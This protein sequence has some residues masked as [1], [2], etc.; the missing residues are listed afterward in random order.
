MVGAL[1]EVEAYLREANGV[2]VGKGRRVIRFSHRAGSTVSTPWCI[3]IAFAFAFVRVRAVWT[4]GR[5]GFGLALIGIWSWVSVFWLFGRLGLGVWVFGLGPRLGVWVAVFCHHWVFGVWLFFVTIGRLGMDVWVFGLVPI[6]GAWGLTCFHSNATTPSI[7]S[8]LEGCAT[9]FI[10]HNSGLCL[11]QKVDGEEG[12]Q[13]KEQ[14]TEKTSWAD[15]RW[16]GAAVSGGGMTVGSVLGGCVSVD[17]SGENQVN[18]FAGI[19][20]GSDESRPLVW[21]HSG[22]D[23][24]SALSVLDVRP[25]G[26]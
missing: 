26:G 9:V 19:G 3:F 20:P 10:A 21:I 5:F 7:D 17:E 14:H 1:R 4:V 2:D 13:K 12:G 15:P 25:F 22:S 18:G 23:G 8:F 16:W 24:Q 11:P 6:L